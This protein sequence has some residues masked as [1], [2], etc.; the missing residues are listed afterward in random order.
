MMR[1]CAA[2]YEP[3]RRRLALAPRARGAARDL[4]LAGI[5]ET[6]TGC[7]P[8]IPASPA[9]PLGAAHAGT[10]AQHL[11]PVALPSRRRNAPWDSPPPVA[12]SNQAAIAG[13]LT[14][15][16]QISSVLINVTEVHLL[17]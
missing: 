12:R 4:S 17:S 11:D 7:H 3:E 13:P 14:D 5:T 16:A 9:E 15:D 6:G 1:F 10:P 2:V 8:N